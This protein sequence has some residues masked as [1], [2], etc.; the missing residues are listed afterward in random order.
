MPERR[1][2]LFALAVG[3]ALGLIGCEPEADD[4][5]EAPLPG[6]VDEAEIV[7]DLDAGPTVPP[8]NQVTAGPGADVEREQVPSFPP[9]VEA[10]A[11]EWPMG[12]RDYANT[13]ATTDTTIDSD[14]LDD[15]GVAWTLP[16]T[17]VSDWG[18]SA[19]T[20]VISEGVVYFQDLMSNTFAIDLGSGDPIWEREYG[21]AAIGPNGP[22]IGYGK[23]FI[24]DGIDNL[25][26]LDIDSG[27]ELWSTQLEPHTGTHQPSVFDGN[28]Y[29]GT[30]AGTPAEGAD[31]AAGRESYVGGVSGKVY[32]VEQGSGEIVWEFQVVEEGFWGD[33]ERNG[34]G[35]IWYPPG[36]DTDTG[37]TFWATGNPSPFPGTI[38]NPNAMS[39]PGP[40]LYTNSLL[41][42]DGES[43]RM[44]WY[45]QVKPR[46]MFDLDYQ[47]SPILATAEIDGEQRDI[48]MSSGKL[49]HVHAFDR[50][51][52]EIIW[53]LEV[54]EHVNDDLQVLPHGEEVFVMPGVWG[55]VETPMAMADGQLYVLVLNLGSRY[56]A[57]GH[58]AEEPGDAVAAAEGHTNLEE[59]DSVFYAID[60]ATGEV[61]WERDFDGPAFG[62]ATVVNDVVLTATLGGEIHALSRDDGET[63]WSMQAPGGIIAW[64]AIADDTIVWPVGLGSEPVLMALR[65]GAEGE[66]VPPAAGGDTEAG[67]EPGDEPEPGDDPEPGS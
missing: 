38:D 27:D 34:G 57:T 6:E 47:I 62:G 22:S 2:L 66:I 46:D 15:L 42:L 3:L 11:A 20:P 58:D 43:G 31:D 55:G 44:D 25:I 5:A 41:A 45:N 37:A 59:A 30:G 14:T 10:G 53:Q 35:G 26:A 48:V 49:G 19:S 8:E 61:A 18:A 36:I 13:R 16:T 39:R 9:E 63:V 32:A 24:Q 1:S 4:A 50:E 21:R 23:V 28:V 7:G 12:N 51:T 29:T 54:G 40:N 33:P 67:D 64:P 17:G 65:L 56:T 52:G 60:V